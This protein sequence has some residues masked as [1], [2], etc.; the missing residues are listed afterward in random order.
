MKSLRKDKT[1]KVKPNGVMLQP[2]EYATV[3]VLTEHG[4]DVELIPPSYTPK[5]KTG[6]LIMNGMIWEMKA[7]VGKSRSTLEHVIQKAAHQARNIIIDLRRTKLD[8]TKSIVN[9]RKLYAKF[10]SVRN[11]WVITKDGELIKLRK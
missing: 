7:P 5:S 1:G 9:A 8:D 2:H 11:L 3:I 10:R 4:Y 6:D